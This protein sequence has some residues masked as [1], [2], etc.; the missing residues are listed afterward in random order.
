MAAFP[1]IATATARRFFLERLKLTAI[2]STESIL[3]TEEAHFG[4]I[5]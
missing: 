5:T 3:R 2:E 4:G 1:L